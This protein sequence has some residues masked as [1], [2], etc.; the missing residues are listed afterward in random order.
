MPPTTDRHLGS[1]PDQVWPPIW[2]DDFR[3][4]RSPSEEAIVVRASGG[5]V[6][7]QCARMRAMRSA[8][9]NMG[10][11]LYARN[12]RSARWE[13]V[14]WEASQKC[15]EWR[16]APGARGTRWSPGL[17]VIGATRNGSFGHEVPYLIYS[18]CE[19]NLWA[20][21]LPSQPPRV[22]DREARLSRWTAPRRANRP[23]FESH[24]SDN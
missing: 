4:T 21:S 20:R 15:G 13:G 10:L 11:R 17:Q 6:C 7:A 9:G 19:R 12:T 16:G 1:R 3:I 8:I 14:R 5:K 22:R 18:I 23:R 2:D 24:A